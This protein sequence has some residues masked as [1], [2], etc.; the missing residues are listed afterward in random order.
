MKRSFALH[1]AAVRVCGIVALGAV[2]AVPAVAR[3]QAF[4]LFANAY[5]D[6][7]RVPMTRISVEVPFRT[8]VFFKKEGYYDSRYA[9]YISIRPASDEKARPTT[10]VL[11]GFATVQSY[12]ET[13]RRDQKSRTYREI[14]LP[15]GD[16]VID[17]Q[18]TVHNTQISMHR[19]VTLRV[20]NFLA[21]GIGF[22]TP[23]VLSVPLDYKRT[24]ARW[25]DVKDELTGAETPSDSGGAGL[26]HEPAVRFAIYLDH[27]AA[28]PVPCDVFYEVEDLNEHQMHYGKR[29]VMLDGKTDDFVISFSVDEWEPGLYRV[30]LRAR[31]YAPDR[32]ATASVDLHVDITRAMLTV[33]FKDTMEI[34]SLIASKEEL[35]PL[36]DAPEAD[37]PAEWAKFWAKRDPDPSTTENEALTTYLERVQYV[38]KEYSQFGPGWRSDRGRI[39]IRYGPPEQIDTAMDSRSQG[40]YEIWRYYARNLTFVFYDMM[41]VGDYKLVEG[42]F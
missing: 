42:E 15:P 40:E 29:R 37:R 7:T 5:L 22:G 4:S 30:N 2:L 32:D 6:S 33:N 31:T 12:D 8:L 38:I 13:R 36:Q 17:A 35:K 19:S 27:P 24:F 25:D 28:G 18:F 14:K 21:S 41:G 3:A 26:E 20:P 11:N 23:T 9:A 10:Y 39:Y 34:L 1:K 16:Y